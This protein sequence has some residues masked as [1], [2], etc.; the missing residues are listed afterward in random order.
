[1]TPEARKRLWGHRRAQNKE[2]ATMADQIDKRRNR[3]AEDAEYREKT[4]ADKRKKYAEDD[5]F[6]EKMLADK[7]QRYAEDPQ[8]REAEKARARATYERQKAEQAL[9]GLPPVPKKQSRS[10][11]EWNLWR[12]YGLTQADYD[13]MAAAQKGLCAICEERPQ[14]KLCVDHCH[15]TRRLRFLLCNDCNSGLGYFKDDPRRLRRGLAYGPV[16][17]RR[18][19]AGTAVKACPARG[20]RQRPP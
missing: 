20:Q 7:R 8:Y 6:R 1:M 4:L 18:L 2:A 14:A 9:L 13:F 5:A 17:Q 10:N 12:N 11:V 3:Y 15:A 19:A 16:W